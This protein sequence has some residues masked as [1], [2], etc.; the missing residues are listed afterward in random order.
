[1]SAGR[2]ATF[3]GEEVNE[4]ACGDVWVESWGAKASPS[5]TGAAS[6]NE[7]CRPQV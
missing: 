7:A 1:M 2:D 4:E 5:S 6:V 3:N